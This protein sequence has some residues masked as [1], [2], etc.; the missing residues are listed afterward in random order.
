MSARQ[1]NS[2]ATDAS[3]HAADGALWLL[4]MRS[5]TRITQQELGAC[6]PVF[7]KTAVR[8]LAKHMA[9]V[10]CSHAQWLMQL[11]GCPRCHFG[12]AQVTLMFVGV[13]VLFI[14]IGGVC[15]AY[16]MSVSVGCQS[17]KEVEQFCDCRLCDWSESL[18]CERTACPAGCTWF[19]VCV[20]AGAGAVVSL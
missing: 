1:H 8:C 5:D 6:K 20:A 11:D 17:V 13:A 3:I 10:E 19:P 12:R 16:G 14:P 15:L 7:T 9:C 18:L 4:R 2:R